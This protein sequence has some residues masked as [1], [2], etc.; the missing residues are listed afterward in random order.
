MNTRKCMTLPTTS[1]QPPPQADQALL[2]TQSQRETIN[3]QLV[4]LSDELV[5][6]GFPIAEVTT[7]DEVLELAY[8]PA[9]S[10]VGELE[11]PEEVRRLPKV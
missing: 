1:A 5:N 4:H 3:E 2:L 8:S 10:G 11:R 6:V 9:T 7:L